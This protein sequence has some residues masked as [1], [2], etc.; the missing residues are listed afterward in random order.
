MKKLVQ[1]VVTSVFPIVLWV[2]TA[3]PA[4]AA[5]LPQPDENGNYSGRSCHQSWEVVD[6]DP[7]GLNCRSTDTSVA[8]IYESSL[9]NLPAISTWDIV[10]TFATGETFKAGLSPAGFN[11]IYDQN[12]NPWLFVDRGNNPDSPSRC[13][14]R[15]NASFVKPIEPVRDCS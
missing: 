9:K 7:N 1:F 10:G 4:N 8:E 6:P 5:S 3:L 13:L 12:D 15:A 2:L 14:V 11:S